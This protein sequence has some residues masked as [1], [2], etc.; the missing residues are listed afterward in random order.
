MSSK[1]YLPCLNICFRS[2]SVNIECELIMDVFNRKGKTLFDLLIEV[3]RQDDS[4]SSPSV[5]FRYPYASDDEVCIK[6]SSTL[7]LSMSNLRLSY[8]CI[9]VRGTARVET[10]VGSKL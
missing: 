7:I 10:M 5:A 2:G 8:F 3:V 6:S 9:T 1:F 4:D